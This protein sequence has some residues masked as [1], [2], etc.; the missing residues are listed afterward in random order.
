[1]ITT[2]PLNDDEDKVV[3]TALRMQG[4][5]L[6]S[7][8]ERKLADGCSPDSVA[9]M[10]YRMGC[11]LLHVAE[12]IEEQMPEKPDTTRIVH[13]GVEGRDETPCGMEIC[14]LGQQGVSTK[15][16]DVNCGVCNLDPLANVS[17]LD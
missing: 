6:R 2:I 5:K 4:G 17:P 13:F 3:S 8:G 12:R 14:R 15:M 7:F 16:V 1:M 11:Q 9:G 10:Y